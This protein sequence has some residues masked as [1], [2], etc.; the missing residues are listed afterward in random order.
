MVAGQVMGRVRVVAGRGRV[1]VRGA[2]GTEFHAH[3]HAMQGCQACVLMR[4][5]S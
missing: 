4:V 5:G 1:S 2:G 3:M